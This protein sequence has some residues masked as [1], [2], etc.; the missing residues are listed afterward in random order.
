MQQADGYIDLHEMELLSKVAAGDRIAFGL[1]F[2][3]YYNKVLSQALTYT[4]TLVE[5]EDLTQDIFIKVWNAKAKLAVVKSFKNYLFILT[6]NEMVDRLRKK[7]VDLSAGSGAIPELKED[8]YIPDQQLE[9]QETY[10]LILKGM[11]QLPDQ[12]KLV[13]RMSRLEGKT[14]GE[15][16]EAL[17]IAKT[18]VRWHIVLA[19]NFLKTYVGLH[20]LSV[21][22]A[23]LFGLLLKK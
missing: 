22:L 1:L 4:K 17:G 9:Y 11:E 2:D 10:Q 8:I 3:R 23:C 16:A 19:L 6:R 21:L 15:I 7:A 20:S 13:F 14:N 18:T 12:Q 5:A